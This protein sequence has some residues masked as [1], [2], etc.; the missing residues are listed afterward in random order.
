MSF[1]VNGE[2]ASNEGTGQR[3]IVKAVTRET[4]VAL[5]IVAGTQTDS[6]G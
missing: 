5:V 3:K 6:F 2:E 4:I 1:G